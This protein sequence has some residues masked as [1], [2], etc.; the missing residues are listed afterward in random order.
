MT[1]TMLEVA[2]ISLSFGGLKA[3][4][5]FALKPAPGDLQGI[6]GPDDVG[7]RKIEAART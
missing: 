1:T 4:S 5:E 3:V 2:S 6:L 7:K